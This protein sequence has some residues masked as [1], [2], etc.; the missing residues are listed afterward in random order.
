MGSNRMLSR[1]SRRLTAPVFKR[2][3]STVAAEGGAAYDAVLVA[4]YGAMLYNHFS[5]GMD[6]SMIFV[7]PVLYPF[8]KESSSFEY[9]GIKKVDNL[10]GQFQPPPP[11][12]Y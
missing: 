4:A 3:S 1:G 11:F 10:F 2:A 9:G 12:S 8:R 7:A 5:R 6:G